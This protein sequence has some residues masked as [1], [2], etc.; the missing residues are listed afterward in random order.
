[1]TAAVLAGAASPSCPFPPPR[2]S[3][4]GPPVFH[5]E[6]ELLHVPRTRRAALRAEPTMQ[7]HILVFH[8]D[9]RRLEL[10]GHIKILRNVQRFGRQS[11][12]KICFVAVP[13]KR[14][15]IR[16]SDIDARIALDAEV[17]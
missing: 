16:R 2:L 3:A 6:E 11:Q 9:P 17:L 1:M 15:A 13:R 7:A 4:P 5:L 10:A 8:H 12:P 14:D